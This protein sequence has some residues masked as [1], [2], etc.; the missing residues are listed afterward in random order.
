MSKFGK[1]FFFTVLA[2]DVDD[3]FDAAKGFSVTQNDGLYVIALRVTAR[4]H[5]RT[6]RRSQT[7]SVTTRN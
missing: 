6:W 3:L 1:L 7:T 5:G 4:R 2:T